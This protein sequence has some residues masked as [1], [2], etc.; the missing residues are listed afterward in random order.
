[1]GVEDTRPTAIRN[2]T[3]Q[4]AMKAKSSPE[5]R[6]PSWLCCVLVGRWRILGLLAPN[7]FFAL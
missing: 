6:E 4:K 3:K 2:T 1:M 7:Y 5:E